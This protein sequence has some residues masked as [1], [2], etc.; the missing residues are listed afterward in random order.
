V[1]G[2]LVTALIILVLFALALASALWYQ[3]KQFVQAGR[4]VATR[5]NALEV[6][7][8]QVHTDT[9]AALAL[10]QAQAAKISEFEGW[11]RETQSQYSALELA[12]QNFNDS[13]NDEVLA[14]DVEQ[15]L[16]IANQ[17]LRLAGSVS[18]AIVAL[19]TAQ[20]HL[21]RAARP[22]F[23]SLQQSINND[24][25]RLRAVPTVDIPALS[26]RLERL[27]ILIAT[28][29]LWVP[30]SAAPGMTPAGRTRSRAETPVADTAANPLAHTV[31]WERWR[32]EIASWPARVGGVLARELGDMIR[33]QRVD[34]PAALLLA[35]EQ[36]DQLRS[37]LRQ[38][39]LTLKLAML[40]RQPAVWNSELD[41][42]MNTLSRYFDSHSAD[43]MGALH[44]ARELKQIDIVARIPDIS[45]S[46]NAV[47]AQR[48]AG[49][50]PKKEQ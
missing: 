26:S 37:T 45:E 16:T 34:E 33:V 35:P 9:W 2:A 28:A 25:N 24:L 6:S 40:M 22:R 48:A 20:S 11:V 29:P 44:L 31:W 47:A 49:F 13:T 36:A 4:E 21:V 38:R 30:D 50:K 43:T 18:N 3:R 14:N 17:Q 7:L 46:L 27:G 1:H 32:A 5:L 10:A 15:L 19:E 8:S 41:Q 12:W 23:A 42:V 39:L